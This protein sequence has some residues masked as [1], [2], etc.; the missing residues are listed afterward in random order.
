M[1]LIRPSA[2]FSRSR[3]RRVALSSFGEAREKRQGAEREAGKH[4]QKI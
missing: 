1:A 2:T 4:K 3:E